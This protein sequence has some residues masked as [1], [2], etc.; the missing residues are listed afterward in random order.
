MNRESVSNGRMVGALK[1]IAL[2]L[3]G[4]SILPFSGCSVSKPAPVTI[5]FAQGQMAPP[6]SVAAN[7]S[8]LFAA[9][10]MGVILGVR[11]LPQ[12]E[13]LSTSAEHNPLTRQFNQ[14]CSVVKNQILPLL[15]G[16]TAVM[17]HRCWMV[18]NALPL[19]CLSLSLGLIEG[20]VQRDIR[21]FQSARESAWLFH[22]IKQCGTAVFFVP[23]FLFM[24]WLTPV[25]PFWFF[26]P[27]ALGLGVWLALSLRFFKKSV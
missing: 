27:M 18:I 5:A 4:L 6:S 8:T 9:T 7:S 10:V 2:M 14:T 26:L 25:S 21:K 23:F 12:F 15:T 11:S 16:L 19:L 13:G 17:V 24:V 3:C 1:G 22:G 20:L